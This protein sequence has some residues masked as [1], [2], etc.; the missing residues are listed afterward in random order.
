MSSVNLKK[1]TSLKRRTYNSSRTSGKSVSGIHLLGTKEY[2]EI[3]TNRMKYDSKNSPVSIKGKVVPYI[4]SEG[5]K[6]LYFLLSKELW[7][8]PNAKYSLIGG[9]CDSGETVIE[10][11]AR[12]L[13]EETIGLFSR[14]DAEK[15]LSNLPIENIVLFRT[16]VEFKPVFIYIFFLPMIT[17]P[18][19]LNLPIMFE[20]RKAIL[21]EIFKKENSGNLSKLLTLEFRKKLKSSLN[22]ERDPEHISKSYLKHFH[23]LRSIHW[24]PEKEFINTEVVSA[25]IAKKFNFLFEHSFKCTLAHIL[26]NEYLK[27]IEKIDSDENNSWTYVS[28][29]KIL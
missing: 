14:K 17:T 29:K 1:R 4:F 7:S 28:R 26:N 9:T 12:E 27:F 18:F 13:Y 20:E 21:D 19:A 25:F 24:I 2:Q 15:C 10:C 6:N 23:E 22:L 11:A 16:R 5:D 3:H 8:S